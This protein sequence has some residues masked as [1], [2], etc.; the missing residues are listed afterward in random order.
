MESFVLISILPFCNFFL[1]LNIPLDVK[2]KTKMS[3]REKSSCFMK[4]L[5]QSFSRDQRNISS[6][7]RWF[8]VF[9]SPDAATPCEVCGGYRLLPCAVCNGSKKS[10]HRNH[11]TAE[12][13]ALRCMNCDE[14]GLVRCYACW[15]PSYKN[16]LFREVEFPPFGFHLAAK[17]RGATAVLGP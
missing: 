13:V 7:N 6:F 9:Q 16:T 8:C 2:N 4:T 14:V 12:L 5:K 1:E 17:P 11:F 15:Q 10:V 3:K